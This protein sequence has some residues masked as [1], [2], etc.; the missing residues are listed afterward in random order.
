MVYDCGFA[1]PARGWVGWRIAGRHIWA[2]TG[3]GLRIASSVSGC[4][5]GHV[6]TVPP[7]VDG[8]CKEN[9]VEESKMMHFADLA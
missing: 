4:A 2:G 7:G 9:N 3:T 8:E 6:A 5:A 1:E